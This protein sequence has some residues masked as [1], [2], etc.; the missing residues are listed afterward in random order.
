MQLTRNA[1]KLV[2]SMYK[3]YLQ[4]RKA[5]MSKINARHFEIDEI[6]SYS[7]CSDW[8]KS[9]IISTVAELKNAGFGTMYYSGGFFANESFVIYMENRFKNGIKEVTDF[10]AKFIP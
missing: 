7:L 4:K 6:K 9:D 8:D 3:S 1:D 5:G 2:C 10:V